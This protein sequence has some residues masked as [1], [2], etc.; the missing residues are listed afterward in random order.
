MERAETS[1]IDDSIAAAVLG[2][3]AVAQ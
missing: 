3:D 2:E 1:I